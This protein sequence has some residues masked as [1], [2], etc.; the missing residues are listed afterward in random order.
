MQPSRESSDDRP[1]AQRNEVKGRFE[2]NDTLIQ[3][4]GRLQAHEFLLEHLYADGFT[5]MPEVEAEQM[6]AGLRVLS[7]QSVASVDAKQDVAEG[8]GLQIGRDSIEIMDRFL[9]KA[10]ERARGRRIAR[11]QGGAASVAAALAMQKAKAAP[12]A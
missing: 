9:A 6:S 2:M 3:I 5:Q 11:S 4:L 8:Y 7:R 1:L 12:V 10:E